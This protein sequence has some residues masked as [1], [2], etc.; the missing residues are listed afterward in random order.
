MVRTYLKNKQT[1]LTLMD[2][3]ASKSVISANTIKN[4]DVLSK[5][6]LTPCKPMNFVVGN[7]GIMKSTH[8]ITFSFSVQSNLFEISAHVLDTLGGVDLI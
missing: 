4:S 3:G 7:G 2:S 6:K 8:V 1:L 5:I